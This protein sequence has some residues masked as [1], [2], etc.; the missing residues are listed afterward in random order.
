MRLDETSAIELDRAV[1]AYA[2]WP[3]VRIPV[4]YKGQPTTLSL[5]A[6]EPI[7]V[8]DLTT[9]FELIDGELI[10]QTSA[11]AIKLISVQLPSKPRI[12]GR[13]LWNGGQLSS[14]IN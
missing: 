4:V 6:V 11:G 8:S 2:G 13:D 9:T 10:A 7:A 12:S 14:A 5:H 1:R 3:G